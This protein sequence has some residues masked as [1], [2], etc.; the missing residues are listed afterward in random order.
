VDPHPEQLAD[1]GRHRLR[2]AFALRNPTRLAGLARPLLA[3]ASFAESW[4]G[5]PG[6]RLQERSSTTRCAGY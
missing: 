1:S 6:K 5:V 2:R 4:I 3:P